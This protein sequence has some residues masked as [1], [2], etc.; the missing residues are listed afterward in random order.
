[1]RGYRYPSTFAQKGVS[2]GRNL[3]TEGVL[4]FSTTTVMQIWRLSPTKS[5]SVRPRHKLSSPGQF[6]LLP[7]ML[8]AKCVLGP[9][10]Q[11]HANASALCCS[12]DPA[13]RPDVDLIIAR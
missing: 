1:M 5:G 2:R 6:T 7:S 8:C 9:R 10:T 12:G 3:A 11:I 4:A 13:A